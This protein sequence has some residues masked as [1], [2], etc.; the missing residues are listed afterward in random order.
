MN[1]TILIHGLMEIIIMQL[2]F[3]FL[4]CVRDEDFSKYGFFTYIAL[5]KRVDMVINFTIN[6]FHLSQRSFT[7]N[8]RTSRIH[9]CKIM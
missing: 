8:N 6:I 1:F 9:G 4:T 3:F 2:G 5:P 7:T